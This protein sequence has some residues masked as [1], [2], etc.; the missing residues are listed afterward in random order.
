MKP[1]DYWQELYPPRS[2]APGEVFADTYPATLRDGRQLCLPIRPLSDGQHALAS[3]IINQASFAVQD[4]LARDLAGQLLELEPDV[5]VGLP[6]L[7]LTLAS[8]VAR[9]LDHSR[10]V[11]LGTSRKFWYAEELSTP[12]SSVTTPGQE[13][14]LYVD[15]RMLP[16]IEGR[17]V[18][19][20][21]DVISSGASMLA[22]LQLMAACGVEPIALGTA[23]LQT[24]RWRERLSAYDG[25]WPERTY[26]VFRTPMFARSGPDG[27]SPIDL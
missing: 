13:K 8:Q 21:D 10:Y 27:W 12:L 9:E 4:A 24:E 2:F 3:L 6:T 14:R 5:I 26:G 11:P 25:R 22:G 19:L 7:G 18:A 23:M 1:E 20:V 16:L 15:P 17:R